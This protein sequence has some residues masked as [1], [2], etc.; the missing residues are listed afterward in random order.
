VNSKD[1][2]LIMKRW[3]R[4][5]LRA[6][7]FAIGMGLLGFGVM[8]LALDKPRADALT[9]GLCEGYSGVPQDTGAM[10]GMVR[11][12]EGRFLMGSDDHYHEEVFQHEVKI[13]EFWIDRHDVTNAQFARFV[14]ATQYVTV[15]ERTPTPSIA[16]KL[17]SEQQVAGSAVFVF[18]RRG[19]PGAW[20]FVKGANWR[21]PQGP[22]SNIVGMDAHPVVHIAYEDSLAYAKWLG[23]DLPTEAQ[24]EYAARGGLDGQPYVWGNRFTPEGKPM[25]NTWQ[26]AFPFVNENKDG[27]TTTSP[28]GCFP[29]NG[30][31]LVDMAGNV[32]QW[33]RTWYGVGH[34]SKTEVNPLGPSENDAINPRR[35]TSGPARVLKGGSHLCAPNYCMRYRPAAR[36]PGEPDLGTSHVGFR[37]VWNP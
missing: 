7:P 23:R 8:S 11:I 24:W 30:Y 34:P 17:P 13:S 14:Q 28:V 27:Y 3:R 4:A 10:S 18:P 33:T 32:W 2:S 1:W 9:P 6:V 37:T 29:A 22:D 5:S 20:R 35:G 36:Q 25:A 12:H 31:G 26:G 21:H 15:A 19:V 16:N